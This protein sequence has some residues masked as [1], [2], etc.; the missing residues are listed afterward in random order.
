MLKKKLRLG[1]K[2]LNDFFQSKSRYY[3]GGIVAM[4]AGRNKK[5]A[6]RFAFV[7]SGVKRRGGAVLRNLARRR[8]AEV[9]RVLRAAIPPGWDVVFFLKITGRRAPLLSELKDDIKHV[10]S[11][12]IL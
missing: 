8:M 11:K 10:I 12:S 7:V 5:D 2:D 6:S 9:V 1:R 3:R 4:R